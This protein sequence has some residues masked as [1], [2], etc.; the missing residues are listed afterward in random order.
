MMSMCDIGSMS[1]A[2]TNNAARDRQTAGCRLAHQDRGRL[3][4]RR[5]ACPRR[6]R[7]RGFHSEHG[8]PVD[9][10]V[11]CPGTFGEDVVLRILDSNKPL[12]VWAN[13]VSPDIL[14]DFKGLVHN[15]EVGLGDG[16]TGS[17]KTTTLYSA[18][19]EIRNEHKIITVEDGKYSCPRQTRSKCLL[20]WTS[21]VMCEL[22]SG[23]IPTSLWWG[24]F[25]IK[26]PV[27]LLCVPLRRG[28]S[29]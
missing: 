26:I 28:T 16:P 9:L 18:L 25:E 20:R 27:M 1:P 10:Q 14:D 8:P 23:R 21:R 13:S 15:P 7:L 24:K 29:L 3:R 2:S 5:A 17:G 6:S 11:I 22:F 19:N 4:Y 12:S